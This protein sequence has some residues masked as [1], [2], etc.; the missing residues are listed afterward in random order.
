MYCLHGTAVWKLGSRSVWLPFLRVV[1]DGQRQGRDWEAEPVHKQHGSLPVKLTNS[2]RQLTHSFKQRP[3]SGLC[4]QR[5]EGTHP[6]VCPWGFSGIHVNV[7]SN[8]TDS[9]FSLE[10]I[11]VPRCMESTWTGSYYTASSSKAPVYQLKNQSSPELGP[12]WV[13]VLQPKNLLET[14]DLCIIKDL[15]FGLFLRITNH[16]RVA[17]GLPQPALCQDPPVPPQPHTQPPTL[18]WNQSDRAESSVYFWILKPD[19]GV[20]HLHHLFHMWF[21]CDCT[22]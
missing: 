10:I 17:A 6:H 1:G 20:Y 19:S 9:T 16:L 4:V 13:S 22:V 8:Q 3:G 12:T 14:L 7:R 2:D 15:T 21:G 5:Q 11:P 18:L